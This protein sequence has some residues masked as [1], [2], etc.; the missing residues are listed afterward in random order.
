MHLGV[1]LFLRIGTL[2]TKMFTR[3]CHTSLRTFCFVP[4]KSAAEARYSELEV[5]EGL[6]IAGLYLDDDK[7]DDDDEECLDDKG[8]TGD[9][10]FGLVGKRLGHEVEQIAKEHQASYCRV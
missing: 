10:V 5:D 3:L 4:A 7:D 2:A 6:D 9:E 1:F 8:G